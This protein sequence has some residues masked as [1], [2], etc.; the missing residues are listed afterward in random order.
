MTAKA[1]ANQKETIG[2]KLLA[3]FDAHKRSMPWRLTQDP[4]AILVSE[5]MLQQ[6][7]VK[8]VIPYFEAFLQKFPTP[9]ALANASEAEVLKAWQGLGYYRRGKHLHQ[10]AKQIQTDFRGIFPSQKDDIDRLKGVGA[11][12]SAAVASI[13]FNLPF[14]CVDGNVVR[15]LTRLAAWDLDMAQANNFKTVSLL[16]QSLLDLNRPGDHNQAMMELGATVCTP[17]NPSCLTCPVASHCHTFLKG[18]DPHTRPVKS[19]KVKVAKSKLHMGLMI[20][21]RHFLLARRLNTGLMA[22]MW[23]LPAFESPMFTQTEPLKNGLP[24]LVWRRPQPFHHKFSHLHVDYHVSVWSLSK[25]EPSPTLPSYAACLWCTFEMA[26]LKPLT[27]VC[28]SLLD[29]LKPFLETESPCPDALFPTA[30]LFPT[31]AER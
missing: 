3:W 14:A 6:T 10:A 9:S 4:Y 21:N 23:E 26:Q 29:E 17:R 11:Y 20:H 22:N 24:C 7:Q 8:T 27:R 19:R 12:T 13:A 18:E 16:A 25:M 15:V 30:G 31:N 5:I 1:L 28:S 2:G